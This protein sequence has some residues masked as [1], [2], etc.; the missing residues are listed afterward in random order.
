MNFSFK[1]DK[2]R[3][4]IYIS[5]HNHKVQYTDQT[6]T[7]IDDNGITY[8]FSDLEK[9]E[10]SDATP[11]TLFQYIITWNLSQITYPNGESITFRY[12]DGLVVG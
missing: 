11:D 7:I 10:P 12:T 4:P 5:Q 6:I 3:N 8:T 9:N 2:N 1:L